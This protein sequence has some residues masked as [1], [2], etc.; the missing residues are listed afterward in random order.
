MEFSVQL[1]ILVTLTSG[2]GP[3]SIPLNRK[4]RG[5]WAGPLSIPLNRKLR[6]PW[7]QDRCF[8]E[9][10]YLVPANN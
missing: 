9:D 3:L 1:D 8:G 4:L 6:G 7:C 2:E 5:P 10:K